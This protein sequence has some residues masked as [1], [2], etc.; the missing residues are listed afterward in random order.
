MEDK[1]TKNRIDLEEYLNYDVSLWRYLSFDK[2]MDFIVSKVMWFPRIT[3]FKDKYEGYVKE[4]NI[5]KY[6]IY[7]VVDNEINVN[8]KDSAEAEQIVDDAWGNTKYEDIK[9]SIRNVYVNCW[10]Q[11]V[12]D[13]ELM[14]LAYGNG[15]SIA[16]KTTSNSIIDS[17]NKSSE[18]INNIFWFDFGKVNYINHD[19]V[20]INGIS[21]VEPAFW[22]KKR[23]EDEKEVRIVAY[24]YECIENDK[25]N[26]IT[27]LNDDMSE[28]NGIKVD[29]ENL[30]FEVIVNPYSDKWFY[31][32]IKELSNT[33][34][35][36]ISGYGDPN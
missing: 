30:D 35:F 31:S 24:R 28:A 21:R 23:F 20:K 34:K 32:L 15:N 5:F 2:F 19:E 1:I 9:N 26:L 16:I 13:S 10:N 18:Y 11:S 22:K 14:W 36:K 7:E 25:Y 8:F 33:Y 27:H 29:I 4:E 6:A 17:I 12:R 3:E